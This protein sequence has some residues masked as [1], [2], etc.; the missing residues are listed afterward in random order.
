MSSRKKMDF[1]SNDGIRTKIFGPSFH[2]ANDCVAVN[3]PTK[4]TELQKIHYYNYFLSMVNVLPCYSCRTNGS[5]ILKD[6]NYELTD[7]IFGNRDKFCKF[8]FKFKQKVNEN[9]GKVDR[10]TYRQWRTQY[11]KYRAKCTKKKN[12]KGD[13]LGCTKSVGSKQYRCDLKII[14]DVSK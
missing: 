5:K 10:T 1:N 14:E 6:M 12:S 3:F 8:Y 13:L 7:D 4:P 9:S 11:E 2:C